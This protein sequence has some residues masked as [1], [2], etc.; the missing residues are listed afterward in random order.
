GVGEGGGEG[1]NGREAV[2]PRARDRRSADRATATA[3]VLDD[4][5]LSELPPERLEHDTGDNV[6]RAAGTKRD[7]HA[8]RLGR[9]LCAQ[10]TRGSAGVMAAAGVRCKRRRGGCCKGI[11]PL[12]RAR[13]K[14]AGRGCWLAFSLLVVFVC[15]QSPSA[16]AS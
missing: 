3:T 13:L 10:L 12:L 6:D 2:G 5:R 15:Q 11:P 7:D 16:F 14:A 4:Q 8:D 9:Q 1:A